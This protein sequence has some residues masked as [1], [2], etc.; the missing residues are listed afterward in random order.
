MNFSSFPAS[1]NIL[2]VTGHV[3]IHAF[4]GMHDY[5]IFLTVVYCPGAWSPWYS[6]LCCFP[7]VFSIWKTKTVWT[8]N[9]GN[10]LFESPVAINVGATVGIT[11]ISHSSPEIIAME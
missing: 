11:A 5:C 3:N 6:L 7:G 10:V 1:W 2:N 8:V 4:V 9:D